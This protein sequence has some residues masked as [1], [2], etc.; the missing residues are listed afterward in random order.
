MNPL[1]QLE[2]CGQSV[3]LDYLKRS[4]I[5]TGELATLIERDG[6]KGITSN[7]SIFEKAIGESDEYRGALKQ[8]QAQADH[9]IS[10]I[11]EHLA[12]ADIRAAADVLR[13]VYDETHG[14]DGYISL[15]C[16]PYLAN[17]TEAT[18]G[19]AL[20]L[21][22]AVD[23][24]NL[25]VKVPATPAGIPAIRR[26]T[27]HGLNINITLLFSVSVYDQVADAYISGL[28]DLKQAGGDVS[29]IGSV[30]SI[31]VSRIDSAVDKR[32]EK[33]S[34]KKLVDSLRGR[35]GIANAKLAYVR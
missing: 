5:E 19:E 4:L 26:L 1:K 34:D 2:A 22:A 27:A 13:P 10:A 35:A 32:L 12:I 6:L 20:R 24:P 33:I 21:W 16:S 15:E 28:E 30:A 7:P 9:G 29:K 25:M 3:W 11:Y 18:V 17:D 14:R 8:F 23:R 31:F